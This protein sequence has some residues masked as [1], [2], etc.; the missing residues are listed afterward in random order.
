MAA[1]E[2]GELP[3]VAT[4]SSNYVIRSHYLSPPTANS[5]RLPFG[6]IPSFV[7]Y[8]LLTLR[9]ADSLFIGV[10]RTQHKVI[11]SENTNLQHGMRM[12]I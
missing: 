7:R 8:I 6:R 4:H 12:C 3:P 1:E 10:V 5:D 11:V 2:T 9:A